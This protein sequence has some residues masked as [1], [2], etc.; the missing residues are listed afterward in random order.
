[1]DRT[2]LVG[3]SADLHFEV[4]ELSERQIGSSRRREVLDEVG[5]VLGCNRVGHE[6]QIIAKGSFPAPAQHPAETKPPL[7]RGQGFFSQ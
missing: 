1:M 6:F 3:K 4:D 2:L 5:A 7:Q